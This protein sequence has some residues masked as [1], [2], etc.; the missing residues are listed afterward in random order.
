MIK[1]TIENKRYSN[2]TI[3]KKKVQ[4]KKH[5]N[6]KHLII[7]SGLVIA[8][9]IIW[10][11]FF[12]YTICTDWNCFNSHL[13]NCNRA[14]FIGESNGIV[15]EYIIRGDSNNHCK[16]NIELLQGKLNNQDSIKLEHQ[17]MICELPKG[18]VMLPESDIGNCHGLLKEGL[19]D[20]II[21]KLYSYLVQNLGR[22]NLEVLD[23]PDVNQQL[24]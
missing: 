11:I 23:V 7:L 2:Q 15:F 19:Q 16:V 4:N 6:R 12:S 9:W 24:F 17:E 1:P 3:I 20:L 13:E 10:K 5:F 22:I 8:F 18:I 21:E 14:K